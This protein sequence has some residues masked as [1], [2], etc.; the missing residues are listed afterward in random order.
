MVRA[1]KPY[2]RRCR[3]SDG[4]FKVRMP[5]NYKLLVQEVMGMG[6]AM[7]FELE[8]PIYERDLE[9]CASVGLH[10]PPDA[11]VVKTESMKRYTT[12]QRDPTLLT[13]A[14]SSLVQDDVVQDSTGRSLNDLI[15]ICK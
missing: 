4:V 5:Y 6:V 14:Y 3:R 15:G 12:I 13:G 11:E 7:R 9:T 1:S 2:C 10:V 8:E